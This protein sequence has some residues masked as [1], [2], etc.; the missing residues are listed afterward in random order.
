MCVFIEFHITAQ[1]NA[2]R[3]V[4]VWEYRRVFLRLYFEIM[5]QMNTRRLVLNHKIEIIK[6]NQIK[7]SFKGVPV[8]N[9]VC[10]PQLV[11]KQLLLSLFFLST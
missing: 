7:S 11:N 3:R 9:N 8:Y 6:S 10:R 2:L 4:I 1:P 5:D